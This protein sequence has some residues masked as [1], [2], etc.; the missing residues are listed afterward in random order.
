MNIYQC[1]VQGHTV[2]ITQFKTIH[3]IDFFTLLHG[4]SEREMSNLRRKQNTD[5]G[6]GQIEV[7]TP[8]KRPSERV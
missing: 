7:E 6:V 3:K 8:G 2:I 1:I 4:G 5:T